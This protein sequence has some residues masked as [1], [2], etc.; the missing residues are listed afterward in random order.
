MCTLV[1]IDH[2]THHVAAPTFATDG[3][4]R[5][6]IFLSGVLCAYKCGRSAPFLN[7]QT[8]V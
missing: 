4:L 7:R 8:C 5:A 3:H 1:L 2:W 6:V